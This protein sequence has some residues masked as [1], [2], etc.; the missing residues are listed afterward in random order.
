MWWLDEARSVNF[1][2]VFDYFCFIYLDLGVGRM[3]VAYRQ[4]DVNDEG[5]G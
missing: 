4:W 3:A 1:M 5:H 2:R